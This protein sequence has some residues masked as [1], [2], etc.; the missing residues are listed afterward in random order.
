[1]A[2]FSRDHLWQRWFC[3]ELRQEAPKGNLG[4]GWQNYTAPAWP[5]GNTERSSA[6]FAT[7]IK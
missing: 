5:H 1:M 4:D 7:C 3:T 6:F 2:M